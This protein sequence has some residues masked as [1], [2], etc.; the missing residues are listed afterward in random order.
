MTQ[1]AGRL[2]YCWWKNMARGK[3]SGRIRQCEILEKDVKI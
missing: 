2:V 3:F 1:E